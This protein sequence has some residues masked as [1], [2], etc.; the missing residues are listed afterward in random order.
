MKTP[1]AAFP[2]P[3]QHEQQLD[4]HEGMSLLDYFAAKC[5]QAQISNPTFDPSISHHTVAIIAYTMAKAM[6]EERKK[7]IG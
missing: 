2:G 6:M 1:E 4:I 5:M 7:H 3:C